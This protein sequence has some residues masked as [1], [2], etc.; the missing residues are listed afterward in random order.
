VKTICLAAVILTSL[1]ATSCRSE[2]L[3][4]RVKKEHTIRSLLSPHVDPSITLIVGTNRIHNVLG[5]SPYYIKIQQWNSVFVATETKDHRFYYHIVNLTNQ[6]DTVVDGKS[7]AFGYSIGAQIGG[8]AESI[9][10]VQEHQLT[11][12]AKGDKRRIHYLLDLNVKRVVSM[13]TEDLDAEGKV[14]SRSIQ[15]LK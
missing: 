8:W 15:E 6:Q 3:Q 14:L 5:S 7:T 10:K 2:E 11:L 13:E 12:T 9:S 1:F 4:V